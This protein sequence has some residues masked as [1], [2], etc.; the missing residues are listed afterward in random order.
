MAISQKAIK[1]AIIQYKGNLTK[2]AQSFESPRSTIA[3]RVAKSDTLK[4]TLQEARDKQV[5]IIEA[6][7]KVSRTAKCVYLI[8]DSMM[9]LTKIGIAKDLK[10]RFAAMQS[11]CPQELDVYAYF[12]ID[13]PRAHEHFLHKRF[14]HKNYR[15]EW[16]DLNQDDLNLITDYFNAYV[17]I[18]P[19][20]PMTGINPHVHSV[21]EQVSIFDGN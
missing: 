5:D 9:G 16:Y 6:T 7:P 2:V 13:D 14:A 20:Q 1:E 8:R 19:C 21:G 15:A 4:A 11:G 17:V 12:E 3:S 10:A 18:E